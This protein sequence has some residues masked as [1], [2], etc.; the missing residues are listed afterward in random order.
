MIEKKTTNQPNKQKNTPAKKHNVTEPL[1]G[2]GTKAK[3]IIPDKCCFKLCQ[4]QIKEQCH[5]ELQE[6][7]RISNCTKALP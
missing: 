6:E 3:A 1:R 2:L 5:P 7:T 4:A